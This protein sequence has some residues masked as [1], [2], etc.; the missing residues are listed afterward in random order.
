MQSIRQIWIKI[1]SSLWFFPGLIVLLSIVAAV[2]LIEVD[3]FVAKEA[4]RKWPR[5]FGAG[6]EGSRS[7]LSTVAGSMITVAGVTFS[8]TIVALSQ[9]SNQYSPRILRNFMRDRA[10]QVVLGVFAGIFTYCLIVL[11]TIRGGDEGLF[12]PSVA[13]LFAVFLAVSGI[14][15]LIFFIHHIASSIQAT[16]IIS[17]S[18]FETLRAIDYLFPDPLDEAS[19]KSSDHGDS[20]NSAGQSI[21]SSQIGY[22]QSVDIQGL[23]DFASETKS[24]L[25]M[26][27]G[28]GDFVVK[29]TTLLS[30]YT[31]FSLDQETKNRLEKSFSID[32]T[33][34][35]VQD[36]SFG[37]RQIVDIA[38][39]AISPAV[40]DTTTA[41][42]CIHYLTA[43]NSQLAGRTI[44]RPYRFVNGELRL[45]T[46]EPTFGSFLELSYAQLTEYARANLVLYMALVESLSTVSEYTEN[47]DRLALLNQQLDR[48]ERAAKESLSSQESVSKI[49]AKIGSHHEASR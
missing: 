44:D 26:E 12:V 35:V 39:K 2:T 8:I 19:T 43:I 21:Y 22:I 9:A 45:I 11:R 3:S 31:H 20:Y 24:V 38:L 47:K 30:L 42:T 13:V 4:L 49:V 28:T 18:C 36:A 5:L 10:N 29:G 15:V 34:T 17:R 33:R 32:S 48:I 40:N 14:G 41:V 27:Q 1:G 25:K 37:I 46:C 7:L 23:I 16:A 6:A